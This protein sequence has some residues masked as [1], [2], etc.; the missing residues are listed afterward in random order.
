MLRQVIQV[1]RIR[2]LLIYARDNKIYEIEEA[3]DII[4]ELIDDVKICR[5]I[6]KDKVL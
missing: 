1:H 6:L 2:D 5:N 4:K 3:K